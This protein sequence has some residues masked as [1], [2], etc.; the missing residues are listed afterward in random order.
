MDAIIEAAQ[1]ASTSRNM[2]AYTV[3]RITDAGLREQLAALA[4]NQAYVSPC[5]EFLVWCADLHRY[6]RA[7]ARALFGR[8]GAPQHDG[9]LHRRDGRHRT[10]R[11]K[12]CRCRRIARS[13]HRLYRRLAQRSRASIGLYE[14]FV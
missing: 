5:P 12:C 1:H 4:G 3:I 14:V 6:E 11:A 8:R 2:Q 9:K 10:G 13:R 7:A